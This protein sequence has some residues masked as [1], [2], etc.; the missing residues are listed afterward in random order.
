MEHHPESG[1]VG[2]RQAVAVPGIP[3][4]TW[5]Y[6]QFVAWDGNLWGTDLNRVPANQLGM[7]D[8]TQVYLKIPISTDPIARPRFTQPAIVPP[9]PEPSSLVFL[10]SGVAGV[11]WCLLRKR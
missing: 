3:G 2:T 7:T 9:I 4:R 8:S 11:A 5:A 1:I 6:V 10:I